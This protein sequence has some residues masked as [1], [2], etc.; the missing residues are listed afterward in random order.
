MNKGLAALARRSAAPRAALPLRGGGGGPLAREAPPAAPL[1]EQDELIWRDGTANPET[2]LD[3]FTMVSSGAALRWL[4]GGL[5]V[6]AAAGAAMTALAPA[7]RTPW[8]PKRVLV[9][10]EVANAPR[11]N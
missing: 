6:F 8:A 9:P 5:G 10:A 7:E 3:S 1:A 4:L 2:A 11:A